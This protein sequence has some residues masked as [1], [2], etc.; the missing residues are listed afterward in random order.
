VNNC[1]EEP[2]SSGGDLSEYENAEKE[3]QQEQEGE[4]P[5]EQSRSTILI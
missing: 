2:G 4:D 1:S 3:T 5:I